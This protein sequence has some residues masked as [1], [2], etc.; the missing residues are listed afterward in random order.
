MTKIKKLKFCQT[1]SNLEI[2]V[3]INFINEKP[4]FKNFHKQKYTLL[5]KI[6]SGKNTVDNNP[7][8]LI[9]LGK[10]QGKPKCGETQ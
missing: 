9:N 6:C 5:R 1:L 8:T 7:I 4:T 3:F 2:I 10:C